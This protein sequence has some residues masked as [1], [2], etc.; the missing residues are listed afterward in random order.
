V[1]SAEGIPYKPPGIGPYANL[2]NCKYERFRY[3][4]ANAL[5]Y[6]LTAEFQTVPNKK[7]NA[8]DPKNTQPQTIVVGD[9]CFDPRLA[10]RSLAS[11]VET[12]A[13]LCTDAKLSGH[14]RSSSVPDPA[15]SVANF[16]F[17]YVGPDGRKLYLSIQIKQRSLFSLYTYLGRSLIA[18]LKSRPP[19]NVYTTE[20]RSL[21]DPALF[22]ITAGQPLET[23]FV[24]TFVRSVPYCVPAGA[25]NSQQLFSLVTELTT[26]M[27]TSTDVPASLS[28]RLTP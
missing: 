15:K 10:Q 8:T 11:Q 13:M 25:T 16:P 26:L 9:I 18:E 23:C 22:Q 28:V 24:S 20:M 21:G 27:Q 19:T 4:I 12:F 7:Y 5:A 1:R 17:P 2:R 6:G 14:V 3:W